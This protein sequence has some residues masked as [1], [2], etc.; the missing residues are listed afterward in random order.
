M[1]ARAAKG[2]FELKGAHV[3]WAMALFFG[4]VIAINVV[5]AV[6]AVRSFPGEDVRRSY[7][8]GLQYNDTL[9][10]RRAQA[11][12]GWRAVV[13]EGRNGRGE[14]VLRVRLS[15]A[16]GVPVDGL[17][18]TAELRRP[19]DARLDRA[20]AFSPVAAGAYEAALPQAI[21]PGLWRLRAEA[22]RGGQRFALE[23][24]IVWRR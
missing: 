15:D 7:L 20:L 22:S 19:V 1:S 17:A 13:E 12:L 6:L 24:E 10:Q 18:F 14:R 21:A 4:G 3:A 2:R 11:A 23:R 8:Q 9:E 16:A 5:F